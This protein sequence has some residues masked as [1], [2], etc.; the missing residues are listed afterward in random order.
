MSEIAKTASPAKPSRFAQR[1][2]WG[3]FSVL[4][5]AILFGMSFAAFVLGGG[6]PL[7]FFQSLARLGAIAVSLVLAMLVVFCDFGGM[8]PGK[9]EDR[10]NRWIFGPIILLSL[11]LAILPAWLDGRDWWTT[12]GIITPYVGLALLSLGGAIRLAAVFVLGRRFTGLVAI[13]QQH[14]L[15]TTGLYR[16]I[17]HPSYIGMLLYMAG[18]VLVFRC[19]MGLMLVAG[20]MAILVARMNAE[21]ALLESEFGDEYASYRRRTWRLVPGVY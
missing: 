11:G 12:D 6:E 7:A 4:S 9:R 16:H 20:T 13:Q 2:V 8:N 19:W 5:T 18:Y 14:R 3:V 1:L 15:Q 10:G 21:E 17:R